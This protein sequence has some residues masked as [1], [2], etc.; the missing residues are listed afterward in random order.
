MLE[1]MLCS[2]FTLVPDYLYRRYMQGK[3]L[4]HEITFY[5]V[6]Y[7][8]RYGITGCL[9]LTI[10]LITT[11]FYFHP[12]TSSVTSYFRTIPVLPEGN[13]RV[14][15]VM[16]PFSGEVEKGAPLFRLDDTAQKAA[17]ETANRQIA[18]VDAA[19]A[20]AQSEVAA[21]EGQI[22]QAKGAYEQALDELATKQELQL[23]NS[24]TVAV[25]E[26]EK[27]QKLVETRQ[28]AVTAA[29]A[30]K[31]AA[32][33]KI[34]TLLPAQKASAEAA[35]AEAQVALDKTVVYAGVA[36]RV[37]Q[38]TLR[39]GDIVNPFMRPAGLLIPRERRNE[40]GR[41][42]LVAGFGQIEAQVMK[43]G[44]AVEVSCISQP[45]TII[46]TVV[47]GV[48]D[49]IAAGQVRVSDQLIDPQQLTRPGTLTVFLEPLYEGGLDDITSGSSCVAFAYSNHHE[50]LSKPGIGFGHRVFLHL[51][52]TVSLV[53][54]LILRLQVLVMPIQMLVLGGH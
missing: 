3:R 26:V 10:A 44:M 2:L 34:S 40:G 52:D 30:S 13:G 51:V 17:L 49:F 15:E 25:R 19:I 41:R 33:T 29:E 53:H 37:E 36:G 42:A 5:S 32:V 46:P 24:G 27:L 1:L 14:V 48:Q 22:Q 9:M 4:G 6:W 16:V 12:A 18:E 35:R 8:L 21:A 38:F 7:D 45:W 39:V 31:Q 11:V 54:A 20:M 23:R 50:E 43:P 28:G 47:T